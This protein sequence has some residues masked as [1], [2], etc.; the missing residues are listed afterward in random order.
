MDEIIS[1]PGFNQPFSSLSHL[2][3]AGFFAI[4]SIFLIRRGWGDRLRVVSLA[5]FCF[6]AVF[7]LSMSGVYHLLGPNGAARAVLRRLDHAAIFVLIACSFTPIHILVFRRWGRWGMLALIWTIAIVSITFK[8]VY[9]DQVPASLTLTL[10]LG[11]GW[12]G[13]FSGIAIWRRYGFYFMQPVLWGGVAYSL[14]A[15]LSAL[16]WPVLISGVVQ[17]HEVFH[18][19]VLIGLGFHWAFIYHIADGHV[20]VPEMA[21]PTES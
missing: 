3:G 8:M 9:F 12:M 4:A 20:S 10:Y 5:V 15:I 7:L 17:S 19:A 16:K 18:V 2:L 11:M 13:L 1:I 21:C 14:G 6:G